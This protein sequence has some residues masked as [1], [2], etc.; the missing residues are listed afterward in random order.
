MTPTEKEQ[1]NT[2]EHRL[3]ALGWLAV[4]SLSFIIA[5][6]VFVELDRIGLQG[7][8]SLI[9]AGIIYIGSYLV[10]GMAVFGIDGLP[11]RR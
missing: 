4:Y 1:I 8:W 9:C 5:A 6:L 10:L 3:D 7:W 11:G 2:I